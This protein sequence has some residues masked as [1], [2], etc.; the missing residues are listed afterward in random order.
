LRA[1]GLATA[2]KL[3]ESVQSHWRCVNVPTSPPWFR[4]E[5]ASGD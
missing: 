1:A 4:P 3:I 5:P 2:F